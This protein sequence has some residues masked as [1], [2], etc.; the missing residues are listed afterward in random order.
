[1]GHMNARVINAMKTITQVVMTMMG[2]GN[3]AETS[4]QRTPLGKTES[5]N[6]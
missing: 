4:T 2:G 6:L 3:E 1:M 5:W